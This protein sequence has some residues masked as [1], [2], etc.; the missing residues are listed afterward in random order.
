MN[1]KLFLLLFVVLVLFIACSKTGSEGVSEEAAKVIEAML[2][3]PNPDLFNPEIITQIG[4]GVELSDEEKEKIKVA[5]EKAELNWNNAVGKY[6]GYGF[7]KTFLTQGPAY[8]YLME[9][10]LYEKTI[11]IESIALKE[12]TDDSETVQVNLSV[13]GEKKQVDV[14]FKY[15]LEGL[16]KT[17]IASDIQY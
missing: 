4:L 13:N 17:V 7:L 5:S 11:N 12:K 1:K 3:C 9:A 6:F 10:E 16:I 14:T 2:T 8:K 15:D